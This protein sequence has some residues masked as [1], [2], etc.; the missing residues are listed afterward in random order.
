MQSIRTLVFANHRLPTKTSCRPVLQKI[1]HVGILLPSIIKLAWKAFLM[2]S[3]FWLL[4]PVTSTSPISQIFSCKRSL[5][6]GRNRWWMKTSPPAPESNK[7]LTL[8][9]SPLDATRHCLLRFSPPRI[10]AAVIP[11]FVAPVGNSRVETSPRVIR[12]PNRS[13]RARAR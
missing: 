7:A 5:T 3:A 4:Y 1:N 12:F 8:K 11:L 10:S 13:P 2:T 9:A 6:R